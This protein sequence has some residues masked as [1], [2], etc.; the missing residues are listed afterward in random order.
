LVFVDVAFYM[1]RSVKP[2]LRMSCVCVKK[3]EFFLI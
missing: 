2:C 1:T 3:G